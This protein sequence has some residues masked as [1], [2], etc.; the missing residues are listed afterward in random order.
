M[1]HVISPGARLCFNY[2]SYPR[3]WPL[4]AFLSGAL[5]LG[6]ATGWNCRAA[7]PQPSSNQGSAATLSLEELM[8]VRVTTVSREEST[9]GES[10]AAVF[11]IT[12]EMIHRSGAT[13]IPELLRMAPGV[14]VARA[15]SN[16]WVVGIRGFDN[17]LN[18]KL[19]VQVDG[20][21]VYSPLQS[22]VFWDSVDYPLEDIDRIEVVRG[23]GGTVWGA[24]AVNGVINIITK[25]AKDTQGGLVT[26][27]G[28][29]EERGFTDFRFGGHI[30]D[31]LNYR[32]YAK[33][34]ER[35]RGFNAMGLATDDW[36]AGRA[37]GRIDWTPGHK[38]TITLQGDWFE[39][40]SG[41]LSGLVGT[42]RESRGGN[43]LG[44]W[45][46]ELGKDS[47]W[48]LQAYWDR[49]EQRLRNG[50]DT[51]GT[52]TYDVDFQQ[53]F[54][55]GDR[56]KFIYGA[57]FR[58]QKILFSGIGIKPAVNETRSVL[59]VF[60]QDEIKLV[61]DRLSL[62]IGSKFEH[63]EFTG[64]EYQPSGRLL[65]TPTKRQSV[66]L[67]VSRAVRTPDILENDFQ[68]QPV[69]VPNRDLHSEEVIAYELG[70]RAQATDRLSFDT[71]L[72]YN[73]YNRLSI[74]GPV[75]PGSVL[76]LEFMNG[77][78]GETYG[79]ELAV[80]WKPFDWWKLS[81]AYS[82]LKLNLHA[83]RNLAPGFQDIAEATEKQSPQ[84]H[85]YIRSSFD[86]TAHFQLDLILRYV[87]NLPSV[88]P[89]PAAGL[90]TA[91]TPGVQNYVTLDARL[92]WK[93]NDN[94]E[95]AVVGQNL[96]DDHHLENAASPLI[97]VDRGVYGSITYRW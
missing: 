81:G 68:V 1:H 72:F 5:A 24:N 54:P 41:Q 21:T 80:T 13:S 14:N 22:G 17:V 19:L 60:L 33:W 84:N 62:T 96:L 8:N 82:Y 12:Q 91:P 3:R 23:P 85:F 20:R 35:D 87:D 44:R 69:L 61:Q 53:Q 4:W 46:H 56:Q 66:W 83:N 70:Y 2:S 52:D 49:F 58:L 64:F 65:W 28:G 36:R 88:T 25:S 89:R 9:V 86:L 95:F 97:E 93:P 7:D 77:M 16:Q 73:T 94:L 90:L 32:V 39:T 29:T 38:D 31:N 10:P 11:V 30:G 75:T 47:N 79:A 18:N 34:F 37:G 78:T 63:N 50:A 55:I 57:G 45:T 26:A 27:G 71:A 67:A 48:Q 43:V 92:A 40:V 6:F 76:P 74:F 15:S 51:F 42:D 59:S